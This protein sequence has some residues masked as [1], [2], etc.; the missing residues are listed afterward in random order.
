[1]HVRQGVTAHGFAINVEND[2]TPFEWIVPCGLQVRMTSLA[3]ERGR[4]GGMACMRRR[5]AHAYAVEHGLRLRLVTAQALERALA[6]AALP[7]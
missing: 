5:M 1:M 3:T 4:Q 2:L 7:A 6:A